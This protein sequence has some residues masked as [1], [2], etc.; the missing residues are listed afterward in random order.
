MKLFLSAD[1]EGTAGVAH[2]D[3]TEKGR[4]GYEHFARQMSLEVTAACEGAMEAGYDD[5]L[6]RDAHDSA[7]NIDPELLPECARIFRGWGSDPLSMMSGLDGS[8][9]AVAFTGYHSPASSPDNPLSHTMNLK[10]NYVLING[11]VASELMINSLT[12]AYHHVPVAFVSG[13]QGLCHWMNLTSPNT[14]TVPV[15][16]GVGNGS[17]SIHPRVAVKRIREGMKEA[18]SRPGVDCRFPLPERFQVEI[19]F[20]DHNRARSAGFYPGARQLD[21]RRVAFE[22]KDYMDVLKF[23]HFVL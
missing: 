5:I 10:N 12:A 17:I 7:R 8:F 16:Q 18:L 2:W 6:V 3:E 19:N 9:D 11:Q 22:T 14:V 4:F 23:F 15:S 1:I 20:K 13:D 21:S